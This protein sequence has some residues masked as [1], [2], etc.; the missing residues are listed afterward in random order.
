MLRISIRHVR[1][2]QV[3]RLRTWFAEVNQRLDEVRETFVQ[4]GVHHE[5]AFLLEGK[6]GPILIYAVEAEDPVRARLA[7]QH[8]QLPIDHEHA[9]VMAQVIA[10]GVDAELLYECRLETK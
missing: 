8:S 4:E 9:R 1:K 6:D 2:D 10:G 3:E 7:F 5:Q